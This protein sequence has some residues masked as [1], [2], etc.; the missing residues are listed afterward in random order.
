MAPP[1]VRP[2]RDDELAD[3]ISVVRVAMHGTPAP[4][5]VIEARREIW[6]LDR[7]IAAYDA[8]GAHCGSARSFGTHMSV[9]GGSVPAAAVTAVGVLPTHRRQGHLSRLMRAQLGDTVERSESVAIL[10]SA[11]YP[12]YGRYGYGPA[13]EACT[14]R[15]DATSTEFRQP[16]AGTIALVDGK[17][18]HDALVDV[19]DRAWRAH[20]GH[21]TW[22]PPYFEMLAGL[23]DMYLGAEGQQWADAPKAVWRDAEGTISGVTSY[24][25]SDEWV[26]NRPRG[27]LRALT[28][29]A[30]T[31]QAEGELYRYLASVDWVTSVQ[32]GLRAVDDP[33]PLRLVDGRAAVLGDRSDHIWARILDVPAALGA[34]CYGSEGS[35]TLEVVDPLGF[36]AGR[37]LL[38]G[39]PDGASC[40]RTDRPTDLVV[41][42]TAL[43][44]AYLGG[45]PWSRLAAAGWVDQARP[46]ALDRATALFATPR[47]P[48]CATSF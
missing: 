12:I 34:R 2:I 13:I 21:I 48:W 32:V 9:P 33:L 28:F 26:R 1:T 46:G 42:V 23:R 31:D 40:R 19:Y 8:T 10:I 47:A 41:P 5:P 24:T 4:E 22:D 39:G 18:F 43:G 20:P 15:L 29:V 3:F 44:A 11:E 30:A 36:A 45:T 17:T 27:E 7:C 25:V 38:E 37:F 6:E 14:V 35:L 16:P